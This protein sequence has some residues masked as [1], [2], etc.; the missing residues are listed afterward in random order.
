MIDINYRTKDKTQYTITIDYTYDHKPAILKADPNDSCADES[1]LE[2]RIVNFDLMITEKEIMFDSL[3]R[4]EKEIM[5]D[6]F[7]G[8]LYDRAADKAIDDYFGR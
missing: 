8:D 6:W 1:E 2:M 3:W 7:Y 5:F 4:H